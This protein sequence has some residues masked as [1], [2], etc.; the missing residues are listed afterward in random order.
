MDS[1]DV[2]L[3]RAVGAAVQ[4][5]DGEA[6]TE[7][8]M[9][10]H[11]AVGLALMGEGVRQEVPIPQIAKNGLDALHAAAHMMSDQGFDIDRYCTKQIAEMHTICEF[12]LIMLGDERG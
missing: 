7:Q 9:A 5:M 1:V 3:R 11:Y 10:F 2:F 12:G 8:L 6:S 4:M